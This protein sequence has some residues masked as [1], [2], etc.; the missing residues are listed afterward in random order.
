MQIASEEGTFEEDS[1][2][3]TLRVQPMNWD[4]RVVDLSLKGGL[5]D[6]IGA[7]Y[8]I[9]SAHRLSINV[10]R[11]RFRVRE[12][13]RRAGYGENTVGLHF[14]Y[15]SSGCA[16][17][18]QRL[19]IRPIYPVPYIQY[20]SRR[21]NFKL[22]ASWL[23]GQRLAGVLTDSSYMGMRKSG[24]VKCA[25]IITLV[26]AGLVSRSEALNMLTLWIENYIICLGVLKDRRG[27]EQTHKDEKL[28]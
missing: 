23:G 6:Q 13:L 21:P 16:K 10:A 1:K 17:I 20:V 22:L 28:K 19:I 18:T 26:I 4:R 8:E 24:C 14:G 3:Q 12:G 11:R 5:D 25:K 9:A 7:S 27:S 2:S 15:F